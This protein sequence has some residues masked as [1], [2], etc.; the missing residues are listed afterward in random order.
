MNI[1]IIGTGWCGGIRA[2]ACA[3]SP[4]VN[5]L[6][7][8]EIKEERLK[9]V[10]EKT[11]PATATTDYRELLANKN[12]KAI[13]VSA[14]PETTHYPMAKESAARRQACVSRKAYRAGTLG[15]G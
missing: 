12:I 7:I 9:E 3:A 14:T 15:S 8:A 10:A 2:E 6:H 11:K 4:W 5:E 1:G 13:I